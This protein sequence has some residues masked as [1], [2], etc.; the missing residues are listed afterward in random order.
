M[1]SKRKKI[2]MVL[3][4]F[5]ALALIGAAGLHLS[6]QLEEDNAARVSEQ[7]AQALVELISADKPENDQPAEQIILGEDDKETPLIEVA[8][9]HYI[10]VLSIPALQL[11]LPVNDTWSYPKLRVSPCRYSGEAADNTLSIAAHNYKNHFGRIAA[12]A[13]GEPIV[14]TD[15]FGTE[16]DYT[17]AEIETV[18]PT[19]VVK[20]VDSMADL[21]LFTCNYDG[22]A[23][24]LV[25]CMRQ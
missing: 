17:I 23:R 21:V 12:L 14:F 22:S 5:G 19:E 2:G 24:V 8:G 11:T 18:E 9:E 7:T 15:T 16:Y 6:N 4:G 20:V 25:K 13:T 1:K 3:I 10:G